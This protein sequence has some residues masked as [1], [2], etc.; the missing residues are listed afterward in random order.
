[1]II[2]NYGK[3]RLRTSRFVV[4]APHG[5]GDDLKTGILAVRLA[6]AL[7][8]SYVI[9]NKYKKPENKNNK[10]PDYVE[11]FNR[12]RWA[13]IKKRFLWAKKKPAMKEFYFDIAQICDKIKERID[14]KAVVLYI[15]GMQNEQVGIDI[16]TGVRFQGKRLFGSGYHINTGFNSGEPTLKISKT[17]KIISLLKNE[18]LKKYNLKITTGEAYSGWSKW[19]GIQF[20]KHQG[21]NDYAIQIEVNEFLRSNDEKINYTVNLLTKTL[22][23]VFK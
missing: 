17:K 18:F 12:L 13:F 16:G 11:D 5:A 14:K 2:T 15:H 23:Q 20:H 8:G 19:S 1:M 4:V 7:N 9:N 3:K 6:R 10:N 22:T 21:R